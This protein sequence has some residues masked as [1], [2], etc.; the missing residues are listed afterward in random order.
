MKKL[1]LMLEQLETL[2]LSRLHIVE[3]KK[4]LLNLNRL[5][6]KVYMAVS[7]LFQIY[8]AKIVWQANGILFKK[9]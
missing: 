1:K 5:Q 7:E 6:L 3:P 4:H 2:D 9:C 8:L